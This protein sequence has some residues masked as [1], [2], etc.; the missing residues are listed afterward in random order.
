M[1]KDTTITIETKKDSEEFERNELLF[2]K[3]S[4]KQLH[5]A[6]L[7]H[8]HDYGLMRPVERDKLR[9]SALA[10]LEAWGKAIDVKN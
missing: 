4:K 1:S 9:S 2:N 10:W 8:S 6:C 7:Y 3:P 5:D